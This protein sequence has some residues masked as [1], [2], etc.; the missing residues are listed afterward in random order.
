MSQV[1]ALGKWVNTTGTTVMRDT[2]VLIAVSSCK[3]IRT[4]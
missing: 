1:Q 3:F 4:D 2:V